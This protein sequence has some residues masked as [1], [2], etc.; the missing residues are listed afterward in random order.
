MQHYIHL[1]R[2]LFNIKK[3]ILNL[4]IKT[5]I[6]GSSRYRGIMLE[7]GNQL[8]VDLEHLKTE[9]FNDMDVTDEDNRKIKKINE[10]IM[11][12][13]AAMRRV[14]ERNINVLHN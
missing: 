8:R 6:E 4:I 12:K 1:A 3:G 10:K 14:F 13:Y 7:T 11:V 2:E 5:D 9:R